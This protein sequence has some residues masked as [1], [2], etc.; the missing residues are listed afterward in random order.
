MDVS[1]VRAYEARRLRVRSILQYTANNIIRTHR[2]PSFVVLLC[3]TINALEG[4]LNADHLDYFP[5]GCAYCGHW[6]PTEQIAHQHVELKKHLPVKIKENL[7]WAKEERLKE[8]LEKSRNE[9]F[10]TD[11][12][13]SNENIEQ[14]SAPASPSLAPGFATQQADDGDNSSVSSS[15]IFECEEQ[16]DVASTE[17]ST[18]EVERESD[19]NSAK[20]KRDEEPCDTFGDVKRLADE[21]TNEESPALSPPPFDSNILQVCTTSNPTASWLSDAPSPVYR[22]TAPNKKPNRIMRCLMCRTEVVYSLVASHIYTVHI[23]DKL[24]VKCAYC[25]FGTYYAK[26][27]T[28]RHIRAIHPHFPPKVIDR[29]KTDLQ[30]AYQSWRSLCFPTIGKGSKTLWTTRNAIPRYAHKRTVDL[31][32]RNATLSDEAST[33]HVNCQSPA[34]N[35]VKCVRCNNTFDKDKISSHLREDHLAGLATFTCIAC[36]KIFIN[37]ND[38]QIHCHNDHKPPSDFE[39]TASAPEQFEM[40]LE[41]CLKTASDT[42]DIKTPSDFEYTASAS[43]QFEMLLEQCLKTASDTMDI[44]SDLSAI[45]LRK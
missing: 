19:E 3:T 33:S 38:V 45:I 2:P 27:D 4:H 32:S 31:E 10:S 23:H 29:R 35:Q 39:Y 43:E 44:K 15:A 21:T 9:S 30:A 8:L 20:R 22:S 34:E 17:C 25:N 24:A 16:S 13:V 6:M 41:Q 42:M 40:L 36:S 5:Y 14:N 28:L 18:R 1:G 26:S 11:E 37:L 12:N 7:D